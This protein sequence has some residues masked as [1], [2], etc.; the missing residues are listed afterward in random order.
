M[1]KLWRQVPVTI[2]LVGLML[3]IY[4]GITLTGGSQNPYV[5][6]HWGANYPPLL[7]QAQQWWRLLTAG[8]LHIG[9]T[10]LILNCLMLYYLGQQVEI[11][12]GKWRFLSIFLIS[13]IWGNLLS[14][15]I[16]PHTIAAGAST[17]IF[18]LLGTFIFLG[19]ER[20]NQL[21]LRQL[22]K[23]YSWLVVIN[24]VFDFLVPGID[25]WGHI[26]GL[27]AGFLA[28]AFV[29]SKNN[30]ANHSIKRFLS[31]MIL[32]LAVMI[33]VRMVINYG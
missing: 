2:T 20:H 30:L 7:G 19:A 21:L 27:V 28:T 16:S 33:M 23:Q 11:I 13:V 9:L 4:A 1:Q 18:G 8:F 29:E 22:A 15:C 5:L 10:H 3:I 12:L 31:G 25:V 32:I 17:G 6:I 26:G 24:L 14:A